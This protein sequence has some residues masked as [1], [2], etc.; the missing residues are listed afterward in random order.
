VDPFVEQFSTLCRDHVTRN[1]WVFVPSHAIGNTLGERIALAGT[2][3]LN[4]R[5]VTPLDIALRMGAPFLVERD[6]EPSEE[7]LGPALIMRLMLDLPKEGGY[8]RPLA[9]QPTLAEALWSTVRELRMAGIKSD[10]LGA[11]AFES[12]TKH[13]ELQALLGAYEHFLFWNNR[14][15]M[16]LVYEEALEHLDWCPI[17]EQDCWTE[18][19]DVV[20]S[21]LQRRLMDAMPGERIVPEAT[22]IAGATVPRRMS[23]AKVLRVVAG[24]SLSPLAYLL[25]PEPDP[26]PRTADRGQAASVS[27]RVHLFHAGGREAEIEEVFR[28]ILASGASLDQVEIACASDAHVS[29]IWEKALRHEWPVTLGPGISAA[30]TRPGRALLE[31]CDWVETDFAAAHLRHLLQSGDMGIEI[32]DE[33][34]TASQAARVLGKAQAGWGR[35]TYGLALGRLRRS[36][37]SR[38]NDPDRS[39]DDRAYAR[40]RAD[41]TGE[42]QAW[43]TT[44]IDSIPQPDASGLVPLQAVIEAALHYARKSTAR[45]SQLDHRAAAALI[46]H[47]DDLR[48]LGTFSC[49]LAEALRFIRE[50]VQGLHVAPERSRPGHL[51]VCQLSQAGYTG[52]PHLHV[53]GLEEGR[54]FPGAAEDPV[55]LDSERTA[56]SAELRLSSD[57]ID[58]S[59]Y[60]VLSRLATWGE[61][62]TE[63]RVPSP[64]PRVAFSYSCRDTREFRETYA[65]WLMLQAFRLRQGNGSLTYQQMKAALGEPVSAVPVDRT[66][67]TSHGAWWL[68]TTVGSAGDGIAAVESAYAGLARGREAER[69]RD[70]AEFTEFDGHVPEAGAVLDPCAPENSFSVTE[71]EGAAACPFRF[72]LKRGLGLRT[73][74]GRERDKDVWLDPLTRGSELHDLYARLLRRC[75]QYGRAVEPDEDGAWLKQAAEARLRELRAE[76]PPATVE[77]FERES[78]EFLAD[79]ELFVRGEHEG[80]TNQGIGFEVSFGRPLSGDDPEPLASA[81]PVSIQ[82]GGDLTFRVAG[83]IDRINRVG[84]E[85]EVLDY[86]AGG[87]WRD[88]WKGVFKGG[89]RLQ[90]ALYGLAAVELLRAHYR[91]PKVKGSLYYFSSQKGR[92][93]QVPIPA[94]PVADTARVLADLRQVIVDGAFTHTPDVKDCQF[95][96][97]TA[98]CGA[99]VHEQAGGKLRDQK[100]VAYGRLAAHV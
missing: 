19:P 21:P 49:T 51:Y 9:D 87:F 5:F 83:R 44:L 12:K 4:L 98:A 13:S 100:L 81:E 8:F 2:N 73:V 26:G 27:E 30:R 88:D 86:K 3:W 35:A 63:P 37:E 99:R 1:K 93:E 25:A 14:A 61:K 56:I 46:D 10:E 20:W 60:A 89:R 91:N 80:L 84:D 53:V 7:G 90:H 23:P 17:Q 79:V 71:L 47:I 64:E 45:H 92:Q 39:D 33:G 77:I 31:L 62:G 29:L 65:S 78:R 95:C 82:L 74:D 36:D 18:L 15:D 54:V 16:A 97:F 43:I 70:S 40:G 32:D 50:R 68:R 96:D 72:F 11:A 58:E 42:V 41:L 66:A 38:A 22:V 28:R 76:M 55:L 6:I 48:A 94:P 85:F 57:R 24:R 59:V 34:F 69:M 75:R 52:R 67:A